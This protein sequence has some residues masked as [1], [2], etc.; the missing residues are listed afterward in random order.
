M[1]PARMHLSL[2]WFRSF[3]GLAASVRRCL[4]SADLKRHACWTPHFALPYQTSRVL[5]DIVARLSN[6][7]SSMPVLMSNGR[8]S[9]C[10]TLRNHGMESGAHTGL[11]PSIGSP[12]ASLSDEQR[13]RQ[14]RAA[15]HATR[16]DD[17]ACTHARTYARCLFS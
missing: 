9:L 1:A 6:S 17:H 10:L 4:P 3:S 5:A 12:L 13:I 16:R 2:K 7:I 8:P 11:C 15:S 14:P